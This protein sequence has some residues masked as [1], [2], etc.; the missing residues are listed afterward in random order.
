MK[1][2]LLKNAG[3][4]F[5]HPI[6]GKQLKLYRICA[7]MDFTTKQG[8]EVKEGE[9]GGYIEDERNLSQTDF[10]WVFNQGKVFDSAIL[11]DSIVADTAKVFGNTIATDSEIINM[12]HLRGGATITNSTVKDRSTIMD[13]AEVFDTIT[14]NA[15]VI[16]QNA[17]VYNCQTFDGASIGGKSKSTNCKF[18]D[19]S[20]VRGTAI[21][22]NCQ[23]GG[24]T[25]IV[26]GHHVNQTIF[27]DVELE[28]ITG[29]E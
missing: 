1:Y 7:A 6:T 8:R 19:T 15:S 9:I 4:P 5:A 11:V 13:N 22:E 16:R 25:V 20:D 21:L 26:S 14:S 29:N 12:G 17:K 2:I 28:I 27:T 10:S 23:C 24:R 18:T 3:D